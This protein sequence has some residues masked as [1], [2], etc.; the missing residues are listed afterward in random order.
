MGKTLKMKVMNLPG[1]G[2]LGEEMAPS[3]PK[4]RRAATA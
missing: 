3:V 1:E 2:G 4:I